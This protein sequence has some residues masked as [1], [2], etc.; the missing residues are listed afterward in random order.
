VFD[1]ADTETICYLSAQHL[2]VSRSTRNAQDASMSSIAPDTARSRIG[3]H[4]SQ[5]VNVVVKVCCAARV[6]QIAQQRTAAMAPL[7]TVESK[8]LPYAWLWHTERCQS[9]VLQ[10]YATLVTGDEMASAKNVKL[11][12]VLGI[13]VYGNETLLKREEFI[14]KKPQLV[15]LLSSTA[16]AEP[17]LEGKD[18]GSNVAYILLIPR[19]TN[20]EPAF[21]IKYERI[22]VDKRL[23]KSMNP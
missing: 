19:S 2:Y 22:Q 11:V 6:L 9:Y 15:A 7:N 4:I 12:Y 18:N 20:S 3:Q 8:Y 21:L 14:K 16:Q 13:G 17:I 23:G 5:I 10:N 1:T